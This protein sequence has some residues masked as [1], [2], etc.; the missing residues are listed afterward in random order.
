M[1]I[2]YYEKASG[3][4]PVIE[5]IEKLPNKLKEQF[6]EVLL[7]LESGRQVSMPTGKN[8]SNIKK[9]LS[10]V[11]LKDSSGIYRVFY[12]IKKGD[13]IYMLHAFKKKTQKI[14][15]KEIDIVL[16]RIKEI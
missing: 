16:K 13:A 4:T 11:R 14:P 7:L 3:R 8:L 15:Q 6:F 12:F 5:F 9:G 1:K 2:K 10:E